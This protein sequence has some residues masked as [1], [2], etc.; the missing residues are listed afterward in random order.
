MTKQQKMKT[1]LEH[2]GIILKAGTIDF[3]NLRLGRLT[4]WLL[5]IWIAIEINGKEHHTYNNNMKYQKTV[6]LNQFVMTIYRNRQGSSKAR[7]R[8]RT[9]Q[10]PKAVLFAQLGREFRLWVSDFGKVLIQ[11]ANFLCTEPN[12]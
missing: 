1:F 9:F 6:P 12:A 5:H 10:E 7:F 8:R 3:S 11:T 4:F 2:W